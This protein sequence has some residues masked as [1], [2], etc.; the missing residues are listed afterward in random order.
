MATLVRRDIWNLEKG[1]GWHPITKAYADAVRVMQRRNPADPTSWA[2]QAAVHA[3]ASGVPGDAFRHQCQHGSWFFLPWHRI[4]LHWFE[5]IVRDIV[6]D[7]P[8]VP[9]EVRESW[10]LPYWD[11]SRGDQD[12]ESRTLPAAFRTP[13]L[14]DGTPNPLYVSRRNRT[15]GLD[16]NAGD[17]LPDRI[18]SLAALQE[19]VFSRSPLPGQTY[20]FGG[21]ATGWH[22]DPGPAGTLE[23]TPHGDVHTNVGGP[24]GF[25]SG[26][27]TAP[28]DPVFWLHHANLDRLWT[29]WLERQDP[30]RS[31]PVD[32]AWL[33]FPFEF[34]DASGT[35]VVP[36]WTPGDVQDTVADLGYTY[37]NL[38]PAQ[39]RV[40]RRAM[41]GPDEPPTDRPP[42]LVGATGEAIEL[43]G[44]RT[45]AV[46]EVG[47]PSRAAGRAPEAA[48]RRRVYLQ[49]DGVR[50][51]EN[52]GVSYAV[53]L[54]LPDGD[55]PDDAPDV[56]YVGNVSFFGIEA[57]RDVRD[58]HGAAGLSFSFD[59]TEVV[60]G[61]QEA[62]TWDPSQVTVTF[63]PIQGVGR[64]AEVM[65][66]VGSVTIG[67][68]GV[69]Y[70]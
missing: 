56:Y 5:Q 33:T 45:A 28:L 15:P 7:L 31:N 52:P 60:G 21:P 54:N 17:P 36:P 37:E 22:H 70:H 25:M 13:T 20:G 42:E 39:V 30:P 57:T 47:E 41:A 16:I 14:D 44:A 65:P 51:D 59:V 12:D 40:E 32:A 64:R 24:G 9:F 3:V 67:R 61:L 48:A 53:Y 18:V 43:A 11:Y 10:A 8:D 63:A 4:Y 23:R 69:Y 19:T 58:V 29:S 68:V 66:E 35:R 1:D 26:F 34:R 49:L 27:A 2:Y 38:G 50:G 62:G 6:R 46:I 55:D